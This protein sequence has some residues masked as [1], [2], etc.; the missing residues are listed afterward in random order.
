L[1]FWFDGVLPKSR[2]FHSLSLD[3]RAFAGYKN[4]ENMRPL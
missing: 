1:R 2:S 4:I 3:G